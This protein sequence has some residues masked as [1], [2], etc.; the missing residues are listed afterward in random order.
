MSAKW[1]KGGPLLV[2]FL[3]GACATAPEQEVSETVPL[4]TYAEPDSRCRDIS[5]SFQAQPHQVGKTAIERPLLAQTLLPENGRLDL[6][7]TVELHMSEAG[8]LHVSALDSDGEPLFKHHYTSGSGV[9]ECDDGQLVFYP[10]NLDQEPPTGIDWD[11]V[12][13]RRTED[14]SL[15]ARK[16]GLFSGMIF[17][18]LPMYVTTDD[19]YL[20]KPVE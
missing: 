15:M 19:W 14:G 2:L 10:K 4:P 17:L 12:I 6:A 7:T 1:W 20:F 9:F 16:G 11:K 3:L 5:G 8:T 13:L 18:M